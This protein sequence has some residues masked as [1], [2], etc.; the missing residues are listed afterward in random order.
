MTRLIL[1]AGLLLSLVFTANADRRRALLANRTQAAAAVAYPLEQTATNAYAAYSFGRKLTNAWGSALALVVRSSDGATNYVV[2]G[3]SSEISSLVSWVGSGDA[4]VTN[5]FDQTGNSRTLLQGNTNLCP[6]VVTNGV[7]VTENG[8]LVAD[9]A[10]GKYLSTAALSPSLPLSYLI[11]VNNDSRTSGDVIF[12]GNSGT[13]TAIKQ[14]ATAVYGADSGGT[15]IASTD[16]LT[17]DIW[18]AVTVVFTSGDDSLQIDAGKPVTGAAGNNS[19][20]A[21]L[22]GFPTSGA[23]MLVSDVY[24]W[25]A[26]MPDAAGT[27]PVRTNMVNAYR[28]P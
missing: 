7:A 6:K 26:N 17:L 10:R 22:L 18:Q 3:S 12:S 28:F 11:G 16:A 4:Y 14:G 15:P 1:I 21:L 20:T 23:D 5:L 2:T 25:N 13:R 9:F 24:V 8:I 19:A 27:G